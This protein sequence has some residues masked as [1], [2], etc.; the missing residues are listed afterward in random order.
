[1]KLECEIVGLG[2][3]IE[4][5]KALNLRFV[6]GSETLDEIIKVQR[7]PLIKTGLGYNEEATQVPK[8]APAFRIFVTEVVT[9]RIF[10]FI[11]KSRKVI[12]GPFHDSSHIS[13]FLS[14]SNHDCLIGNTL[15][16]FVTKVMTRETLAIEET[17]AITNQVIVVSIDIHS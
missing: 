7:S 4:K 10:Y 8:P 5:T 14:F 6:K 13:L 11:F 12:V 16:C 9:N 2:K 3:E 1:M 15:S 17:P